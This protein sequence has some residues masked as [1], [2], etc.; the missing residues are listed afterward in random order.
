MNR[1][2]KTIEKVFEDATAALPHLE[3]LVSTLDAAK[4]EEDAE[5]LSVYLEMLQREEDAVGEIWGGKEDGSVKEAIRSGRG[6]Y[7]CLQ[8]KCLRLGLV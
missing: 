2:T 1:G 8:E 5:V 6:D 3:A 7:R 4:G